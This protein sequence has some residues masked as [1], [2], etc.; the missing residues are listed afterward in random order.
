MHSLG[1]ISGMAV[2]LLA[3]ALAAAPGYSQLPLEFYFPS[4]AAKGKI[5]RHTGYTLSFSDQHRQ[6]AWVLYQLTA[7]RAAGKVPVPEF[8]KTDPEMAGGAALPGDYAGTGYDR[9]LLVPAGNLQWSK[10]A[11][12]EAYLMSNVSPM[13][14]AFR[15]GLWTE[16]ETQVRTWAVANG[17]VYVIAGPVL[18]GSLLTIGKSAIAAPTSFYAVVLDNREPD[19]KGIGFILPNGPSKKPL[20]SYAVS[21]DVVEKATGLNFFPNLPAK[22]QTPLEAIADTAKWTESVAPQQASGNESAVVTISDKG[23]VTGK[24]FTPAVLCRGLDSEGKRCKR[25]TTNPNGFCWEHQE[26]AKPVMKEI[27]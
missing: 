12:G 8:Y 24:T 25:M 14:A 1:K 11:A 15:H 22:V 9:G 3:L 21:I 18:K 17:E 13:K 4:G 2:F 26:Q 5:I 27:K 20:L 10:S 6:A 23:K 7:E 16:L 19:V